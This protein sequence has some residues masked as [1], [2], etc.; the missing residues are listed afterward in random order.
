MTH[1]SIL[2]PDKSSGT[3]KE[4][5][6]DIA[7]TLEQLLKQK[8]DRIK[9][10]SDVQSEIEKICVEIAGNIKVDDNVKTSE[11][12]E[13]DLTIEKLDEFQSQL[14]ELRKEKVTLLFNTLTVKIFIC[15]MYR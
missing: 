1:F 3:I 12:D 15:K 8:E 9:E 14:H 13:S 5:L 7:P 6:T 2:Q 4:Q 11:V 10:F